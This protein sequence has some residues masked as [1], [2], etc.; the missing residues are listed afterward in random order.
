[1][2]PLQIKF[3]DFPQTKNPGP[4]PGPG[5]GH[6]PGP[7][8]GPGRP[9]PGARTKYFRIKIMEFDLKW[10]HMAR[11]ELILR[12]DGAFLNPPLTQKKAMEGPQIQKEFKMAPGTGG[13]PCTRTNETWP[14]VCLP[15]FLVDQ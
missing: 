12:L 2:D 4:G 7:G 5:P 13:N 11:Y 14:Y 3:H 10:V 1:M 6:G 9:G 8:S 15:I